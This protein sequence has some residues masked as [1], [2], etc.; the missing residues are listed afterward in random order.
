MDRSKF[1]DS[2]AIVGIG[3]T[4]FSRNSGRSELQMAAEA[5]LEAVDDAGLRID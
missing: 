2:V 1:R 5:I 3:S 4:E